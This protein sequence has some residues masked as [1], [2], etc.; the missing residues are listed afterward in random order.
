[1]VQ[2]QGHGTIPSIALEDGSQLAQDLLVEAHS[3]HVDGDRLG[4]AL[5]RLLQRHEALG[6][7]LRPL[8]ADFELAAYQQGNVRHAE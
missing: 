2:L 5:P 4:L 3:A 8:L 1:M 7:Q 6:Y